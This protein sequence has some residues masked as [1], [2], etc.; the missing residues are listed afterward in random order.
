[1]K[2]PTSRIVGRN[3]SSSVA[4]SDR[5]V[6]GAL[7][8]MTTFWRSSSLVSWAGSMKVGTSVL[9]LVTFTGLAL[10]GGS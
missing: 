10:P 2:N 6:S 1:M 4:H 5:P 9:N 3:P 7:A 8:L